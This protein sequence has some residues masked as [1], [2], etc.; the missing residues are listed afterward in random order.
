MTSGSDE[1]G[2]NVLVESNSFSTSILEVKWTIIEGQEA[3]AGWVA[4]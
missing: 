1:C 2:I 4:G 3:S